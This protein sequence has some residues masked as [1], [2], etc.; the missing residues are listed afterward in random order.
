MTNTEMSLR[1]RL[2]SVRELKD[3][4]KKAITPSPQPYMMLMKKIVHDLE[5]VLEEKA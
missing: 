5:K 3:E 2:E 1:K 4:Y